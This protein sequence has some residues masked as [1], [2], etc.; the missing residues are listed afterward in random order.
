[1][2]PGS[3]TARPMRFSGAASHLLT[4][5]PGGELG[6]G[7]AD[8]CPGV[9]VDF[10]ELVLSDV[11]ADV[12]LHV[13]DRAHNEFVSQLETSMCKRISHKASHAR[14]QRSSTLGVGGLLAVGGVDLARDRL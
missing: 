8:S 9:R 7:L 14:L 2:L 11:E 6:D 10:V 3:R 1:M 13:L 4:C 5:P 12:V